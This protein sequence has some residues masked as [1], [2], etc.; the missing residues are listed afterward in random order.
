MLKTLSTIFFVSTII[1]DLA[2]TATLC[3][4]T[5]LIYK[6]VEVSAT[7][8]EKCE[9]CKTHLLFM[10]VISVAVTSIFGLNFLFNLLKK[11]AM[12]YRY[13]LL[14][15]MICFPAIL[16]SIF[17]IIPYYRE[18][19]SGVIPLLL[20]LSIGISSG[21]LV[22]FLLETVYISILNELESK[23]R[24]KKFGII[25]DGSEETDIKLLE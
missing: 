16:G 14:L 22:S 17:N 8:E 21:L 24:T 11:Y 20:Y 3:G 4:F 23:A 1:I 25:A 19:K 9:T 5:F 13:M 2:S 10:K 6:K 7:L 12:K 18:D 15:K